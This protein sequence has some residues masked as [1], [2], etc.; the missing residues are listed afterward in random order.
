MGRVVRTGHG[1]ATA[2]ASVPAT[3][4]APDALL[5]QGACGP[6]PIATVL[7]RIAMDRAAQTTHGSA[8][9]VAADFATITA[10]AHA[11]LLRVACGRDPIVPRGIAM[12]RAVRTIRG[13]A[14]GAV[15]VAAPLTTLAPRALLRTGACGLDPI[16]TMLPRTIAKDKGARTIHGS[17]AV[18]VGITAGAIPNASGIKGAWEATALKK[19]MCGSQQK[20]TCKL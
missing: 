11:L 12:G 3:T 20:E 9:A 5:R 14:P 16:A 17:A 2:A 8:A 13:N 19:T 10:A 7:A 15:G 4:P 18:A 1:S 6:D